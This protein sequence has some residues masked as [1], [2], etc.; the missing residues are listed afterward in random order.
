[1]RRLAQPNRLGTVPDTGAHLASAWLARARDHVEA[2]PPD[3]CWVIPGEREGDRVGAL[4]PWPEGW[5]LRPDPSG[6]AG[7]RR[8][9]RRTRR[10]VWQNNQLLRRPVEHGRVRAAEL[11][12][13]LPGAAKVLRRLSR[14]RG[15]EQHVDDPAGDR[16]ARAGEG[17][18][19]PQP[20]DVARVD[21]DP[22]Q[23]RIKGARDR[24]VIDGDPVADLDVRRALVGDHLFDVAA[25]A[26]HPVRI[27]L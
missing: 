2:E 20:D 17:S 22:G 4:R 18:A 19:D 3:D 26:Q 11:E 24:Y 27:H 25:E 12:R 6:A 8:W 21:P 15:G 7:A 10:R 1:M 23:A 5:Q 14:H 16:H 9:R 13:D